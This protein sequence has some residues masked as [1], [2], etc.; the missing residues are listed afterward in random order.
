VVRSVKTL[1]GYGIV[2]ADGPVGSVADFYFDDEQ[3]VI[4]YLIVD[5]GKWLP[6]RQVL[7]SPLSIGRTDW[8]AQTIQLSIT[9]EQVKNSPDIIAHQPV[10]RRQEAAYFQYYGYPYYWGSESL[11]G[12]PTAITPA[13]VTAMRSRQEE[14][15]RIAEQQGDEHL[16][17]TRQVIGYRLH[18]ADGE[19][20][21]VETFLVDDED[22]AIR[23]MVVDTSNWWFG[24]HVLVPPQWIR[25]VSWMDQTVDVDLTR[26][27]VK[28]APEYDPAAHIERQ[29]ETD[30]FA[31]YARPG[32]WVPQESRERDEER[33]R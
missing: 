21:H 7:I 13:D 8:D 5:T 3:W 28:G 22:W 17:S 29:W 2:A 6:G 26:E 16:R 30:Y 31:H 1:H 27:K 12:Y 25:N 24:K 33:R 10:S 18:A 15:E 23:Y 9:R 4:R 20:G 19:L 11:W 32:Y 14:Q